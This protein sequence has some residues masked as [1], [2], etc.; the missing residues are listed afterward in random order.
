MLTPVAYGLTILLAAGIIVIGARFFLSPHA[1]ASGFGVPM[2][3]GFAEAYL[4]SKDFATSPM[5]YWDS[6]S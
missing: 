6:S 4:I 2:Q 1:A 5:A 3:D